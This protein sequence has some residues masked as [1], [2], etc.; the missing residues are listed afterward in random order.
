MRGATS[1]LI[2][3]L[4]CVV[5]LAL[6]FFVGRAQLNKK[7]QAAE[8]EQ[9]AVQSRLA[10]INQMREELPRLM[11]QLPEWRERL[12]LYKQ[13][14][15]QAIQDE[16]FLSLLA[17]QLEAQDVTLMSVEVA[18]K[19]AWLGEIGEEQEASLRAK[20][21]EPT[22]ARKVKA[23]MYSINLLGRFEN[24]LAAFENMKQYGRLY[25][26]D[27]VSGPAGGAP[28][29]ITETLDPDLLA[30][31]VTGRIYYG[32]EDSYLTDAQ[33]IK[34][35]ESAVLK[36]RARAIQA[37]ISEDGQQALELPA[38]P[39]AAGEAEPDPDGEADQ[40]GNIASSW[41]AT[42]VRH[43]AARTAAQEG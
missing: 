40:D 8:A 42:A 16:E 19:G 13:A 18:P 3:V 38:P 9:Q 26:I 43:A 27:E 15:P 11:E 21:I 6:Y 12:A 17:R 23:A 4:I 14:I 37:E 28:G 39:P 35:F 5:V 22:E 32:I 25:T 30:I 24:I 7:I 34:V 36:P 20:G 31:Q 2:T 1:I 33:L 41:P 29:A 10:R